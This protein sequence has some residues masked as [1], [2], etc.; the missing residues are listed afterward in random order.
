MIRV[1]II[2]ASDKGS[3]GQRVDT[4]GDVIREIIENKAGK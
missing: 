3:A 1:G 4:S 2:T